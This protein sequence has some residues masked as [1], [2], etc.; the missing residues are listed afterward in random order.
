MKRALLIA[1]VALAS[2]VFVGGAAGAS[3]RP[4][5]LAIT[6]GPD[7]EINPVTNG[8]HTHQLSRAADDHYDAR[9]AGSRAR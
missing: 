2:V 6:F 7:L 5:V 1:L 3:S 4:R 9:R 8:Y